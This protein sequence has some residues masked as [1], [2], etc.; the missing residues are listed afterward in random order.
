MSF[1]F[2]FLLLDDN[3]VNFYNALRSLFVLE[4]S[5]EYQFH[6]YVTLDFFF[7]PYHFKQSTKKIV[8]F[9]CNNLVDQRTTAVLSS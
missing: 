1:T 5:F 4:S 8:I 2:R 9:L 6:N 3:G 7:L